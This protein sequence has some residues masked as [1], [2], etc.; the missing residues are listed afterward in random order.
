MP[1]RLE[2]KVPFI[3]QQR[4]LMELGELA[5]SIFKPYL[6][7]GEL[8]AAWNPGHEAMPDKFIGEIHFF[9]QKNHTVTES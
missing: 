1:V 6:F 3:N 7:L 4:H 8:T 9:S 2:R 5:S